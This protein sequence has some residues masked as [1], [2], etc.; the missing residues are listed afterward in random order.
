MCVLGQYDDRCTTA[1]QLP[2][3][4][5]VVMMEKSLLS[6]THDVDAGDVLSLTIDL[7]GKTCQT[8]YT[9]ADYIGYVSIFMVGL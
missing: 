3:A 2:T 6:L 5:L 1:P 8:S 9:R 7:L 4:C